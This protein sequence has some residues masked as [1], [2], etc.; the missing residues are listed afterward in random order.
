MAQPTTASQ[1]NPVT[2][3]LIPDGGQYSVQG[4]DF[5]SVLPENLDAASWQRIGKLAG[6]IIQAI[7]E[8]DNSYTI[9]GKK[10]ETEIAS[11]KQMEGLENRFQLLFLP[12]FPLRT[13]QKANSLFSKDTAVK[14]E[15]IDHIELTIVEANPS[16]QLE[17]PPP[18]D[19]LP[20]KP[21]TPRASPNPPDPNLSKEPLKQTG[22]EDP[23]KV[24]E[25]PSHPDPHIDKSDQTS[26]E[27]NRATSSSDSHLDQETLP[28]QDGLIKRTINRLRNFWPTWLLLLPIWPFVNLI[29]WLLKPVADEE[30]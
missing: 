18:P 8:G 30:L 7:Q 3:H 17:T 28:E 6:V 5:A 24:V 29:E 2:W 23:S 4:G 9:K 13:V 25:P 12:S 11:L 15:S 10:P 27:K 16:P 20:P 14:L 22:V 1:R 26:H 19:P 21:P